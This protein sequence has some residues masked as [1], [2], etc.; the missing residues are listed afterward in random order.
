MF[1]ESNKTEKFYV[2]LHLKAD[3]GSVFYI[4]KG[5][6][7]RAFHN[8]IYQRSKWWH[9]VANK[10]GVKVNIIESFENEADALSL[11]IYLIQSYRQLGAHLI[12]L[13]NGGDG[14]SGYVQSEET[15]NKHRL[16]SLKAWG[17]DEFKIAQS[18]KAKETALKQWGSL[19]FKEKTIAGIK[20]LHKDPIY[21]QY[22]LEKLK[23]MS[24]INS[25]TIKNIETGMIFKNRTEAVLWLKAIG[26]KTANQVSIGYALNGRYST[27]YNYHWEYI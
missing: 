16:A 4:G 9:H 1:V 12:N 20:R 8:K 11:E 6:G 19:E 21:R 23:K 24:D 27:A 2:Y 13:T 26:I 15:K 7:K 17:N 14:A 3:D 5:Q 18:L 25:R 22:N 10:H